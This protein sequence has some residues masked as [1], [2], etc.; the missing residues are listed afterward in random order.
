MSLPILRT[1]RLTLRPWAES[2]IDTLHALWTEPGVR[3]YLWDNL[4]IPRDRA[5]VAVYSALAT[6]V[7]HGIG[8]WSLHLHGEEALAGF[9]GFRFI[10]DSKE[11][12]LLYGLLP[13]LWGQ[14]LATEASQAALDYLWTCTPFLRVYARTDS[15]NARSV[16]VMRRLGMRHDCSTETMII[17]AL[18]RP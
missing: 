10:G 7:S 17:Y 16:E 4:V 6:S 5:A 11:V 2:D 14:G 9:C 13:A 1:A 12:E 3:R 15:P 18:E 8:C